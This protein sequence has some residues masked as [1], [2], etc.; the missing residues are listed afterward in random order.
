MKK[1]N[2]FKTLFTVITVSSMLVACQKVED[3]RGPYISKEEDEEDPTPTQAPVEE[4]PTPTEAEPEP[5]AVPVAA[6][7]GIPEL[8][9]SNR[10]KDFDVDGKGYELSYTYE[11][12]HTGIEYG[13]S[14]PGLRDSLE[15]IAGLTEEM[16][17]ESCSGYA[18]LL[19]SMSAEEL[20]HEI[21]MGEYPKYTYNRVFTRRADENVLSFMYENT[22]FDGNSEYDEVCIRAYNLYVA[23]GSEVKLSDVVADED[24]FYDLLSEKLTVT[25]HEGLAGMQDYPIDAQRTREEMLEYMD[26]G[27]Y[28]WALEPQGVSFYFDTFTFLPEVASATVLFSEDVNGDIFTLGPLTEEPDEWVMKLPQ[29]VV[30]AFDAEDDGNSDTMRVLELKEPNRGG[31]YHFKVNLGVTVYY[32]GD[33]T[34]IT[35]DADEQPYDYESYLVHKDGKTVLLLK[36]DE[37]DYT[38]MDTYNLSGGKISHADEIE[39]GVQFLPE[40]DHIWGDEINYP[41]YVITDSSAIPIYKITNPETWECSFAD[42][43][44]GS[45][46]KMSVEWVSGSL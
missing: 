20:K 42:M 34:E 14:H 23:D 21:S 5:T 33:P 26:M 4:D 35:D 3:P 36:Y 25:V 6:V 9:C 44:I 18:E 29:D 8:V 19:S 24:A 32:N 16:V 30:T 12:L 1:N 39:G 13:Q 37:F 45:D 28:S 17:G 10:Y 43:T 7:Q 15:D 41:L 31:D 22:S 11:L 40:K 2:I 27:Q 38:Y 46:G